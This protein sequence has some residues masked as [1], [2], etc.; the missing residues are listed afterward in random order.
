MQFLRLFKP[1]WHICVSFRARNENYVCR[2]NIEP[3]S[4]AKTHR[5]GSG[6]GRDF[7][8][9]QRVHWCDGSDAEYQSLCDLMVEH[10]TFIKLNEKLRPELLSRALASERRGARGRPDFH[11]LADE[12]RSRADEQLG[13]SGRDEKDDARTVQRLHERPHAVCDSVCDGAAGFADLQNRN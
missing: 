10:G 5:L 12:R 9:R 7:A 3:P 4:T 6:N 11:L 13:R 8:S 2:Q 1:A